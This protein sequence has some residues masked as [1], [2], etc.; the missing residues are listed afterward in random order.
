MADAAD[1][2]AAHARK[3]QR[4]VRVRCSSGRTLDAVRTRKA[5]GPLLSALTL[6]VFQPQAPAGDVLYF[7]NERCALGSMRPRRADFQAR[8]LTHA[9]A[10]AA[11]LR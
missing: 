4:M 5:S 10:L 3:K 9:F 1:G 7:V 11:A 6:F 8:G 2:D